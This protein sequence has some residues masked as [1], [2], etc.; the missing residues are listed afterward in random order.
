MKQ[1]IPKIIH[2]CWFSNDPLPELVQKCIASWRKY[3]PDYR[4][5]L[6]DTSAFDMESHPFVSEAFAAKKYAFAADYVRLYALYHHGGIYLDSDVEVKRSM[7]KLLSL[8]AFT[9]FEDDVHIQM[10]VLGS[11]KGGV[12]VRSML[13]Y[14]DGRHFVLPDGSYDVKTN[15]KIATELMAGRGFVP[16]NR[17]Q[18]L[19]DGNIHIFP[20]DYFCPKDFASGE[21]RITRRTYAIHHFTGSWLPEG[22]RHNPVPK[23][24][25]NIRRRL[26]RLVRRLRGR[27]LS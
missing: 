24:K 2:Y 5:M 19:D 8:K 27:P 15:V 20:R 4:I 25:T 1:R 23:Y 18:V 10:A 7:D 17:Y 3:L 26:S 16:G 22:Q 14:Y 21:M 9:G 12:W 11:E 13:D 6:W